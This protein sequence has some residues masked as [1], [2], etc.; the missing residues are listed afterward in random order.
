MINSRYPLLSATLLRFKSK[1]LHAAWAHLLPKLRW[2]F[3]EFLKDGYLN[4]LGYSPHPPVSVSGTG[5]STCPSGAFLGSTGSAR[6]IAPEG[7]TRSSPLRVCAL[8]FVALKP[9]GRAP[10]R[11]EPG[12]PSPGE[13]YPSPSPLISTASSW[14][15]NINLFSIAYASRPRLRARLTPGGSALP[16]NPWVF[17]GQVSHLAC[18]YSCQHH[19]L[20]NLQQSSR[21]TFTGNSNAPLPESHA[22]CDNPQLRRHA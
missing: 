19:L 7:L 16:G 8:P 9:P 3:A 4:A 10:Y 2:Q 12:H 14:Y 1:S 22:R 15:R 17:G 6:R 11:L 21:S 13:T 18:R 20:E 5:T